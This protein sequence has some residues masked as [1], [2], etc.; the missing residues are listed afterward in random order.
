M[1]P[2][3]IDTILSRDASLDR[4]DKYVSD[5]QRVK[6]YYI[7]SGEVQRPSCGIL[8]DLYY[9]LAEDRCQYH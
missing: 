2:R 7:H 3:I 6:F 4:L 9:G 8:V 5:A 1:V